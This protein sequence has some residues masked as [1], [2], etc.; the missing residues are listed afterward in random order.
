MIV[1]GDFWKP[2]KVCTISYILST[3]LFNKALK[4]KK[5]GYCMVFL[6]ANFERKGNWSC[7]WQLPNNFNLCNRVFI[8]VQIY[9]SCDFKWQVSWL[10]KQ[11]LR[12]HGLKF[13]LKSSQWKETNSL[14]IWEPNF[15]WLDIICTAKTKFFEFIADVDS[16]IGL[17][18]K[19]I[20]IKKSLVGMSL[21]PNCLFRNIKFYSFNMSF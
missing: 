1:V 3:Y 6:G 10:A 4:K 5:Q 18:P 7:L 15:N 20:S 14:N 2:T 12:Y 17:K 19:E 21:I 8:Y 16:L 13:T 11:H 9:P